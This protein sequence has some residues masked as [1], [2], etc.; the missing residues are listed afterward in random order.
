MAHVLETVA[1]E[2][3]LL[4]YYEKTVVYLMWQLDGQDG[5]LLT[6][7]GRERLVVYL[8]VG[9]MD[10]CFYILCSLIKKCE[11]LVVTEIVYENDLFLRRSDEIGYVGI[12]V[13][14]TSGSE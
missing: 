5:C 10:G 8:V 9:S 4:V 13:P 7:V 14:H 3:Y 11:G 1:Q 12:C 2:I 6:V